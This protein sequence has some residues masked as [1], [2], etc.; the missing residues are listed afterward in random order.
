MKWQK[1]AIPKMENCI[2][3]LNIHFRANEWLKPYSQTAGA[4]FLNC[5]NCDWSLTCQVCKKVVSALQG[6]EVEI[7]EIIDEEEFINVELEEIL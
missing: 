1:H 3:K 7:E 4:E 6:P 2:D 5:K